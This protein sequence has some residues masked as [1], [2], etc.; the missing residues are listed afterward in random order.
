LAR[1]Q[2]ILTAG[3]GQTAAVW[4]AIQRAYAWVHRAAHLLGNEAGRDVFA[5]RREYRGLLAEMGREQESLGALAPA[6]AVFRKVSRSY[7]PGLFWCYTTPD[8]PAT[9]NDLEHAFGAVRYHERRA[10]GRRGAS[11]TLVVR[12]QVRLVAALASGGQPLDADALRPCDLTAWRALRRVL[13]TRHQTRRAQC[14]FRRDP[15]HYLR[16]LEDALLKPSLPS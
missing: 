5:L 14:R 8:L 12:G 1:L 9:N 4:P 10:T 15:H 2:R 11:P 6:I 7:W 13:E 16:S 3:L